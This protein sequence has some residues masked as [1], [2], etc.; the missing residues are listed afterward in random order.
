[1]RFSHTSRISATAEPAN[2]EGRGELAKLL[3]QATPDFPGRYRQQAEAEP[4]RVVAS[5]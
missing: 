2:A 5:E 4:P 3:A 1:M